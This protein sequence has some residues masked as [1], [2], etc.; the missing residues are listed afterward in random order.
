MQI[1]CFLAPYCPVHFYQIGGKLQGYSPSHYATSGC[2]SGFLFTSMQS[3]SPLACSCLPTLASGVS[4]KVQNYVS[5]NFYLFSYLP[6]MLSVVCIISSLTKSLLKCHLLKEKL[7]YFLNTSS[8]ELF[9]S[10][11]RDSI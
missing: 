7:I 9:L 1:S 4:S 5:R 2:Y 8:K 11:I 10:A 3:C 6:E